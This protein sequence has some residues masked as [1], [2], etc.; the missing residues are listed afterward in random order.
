MSS[1]WPMP[2]PLPEVCCVEAVAPQDGQRLVN[3][4]VGFMDWLMLP[5]AAW[6]QGCRRR[7]GSGG[8]LSFWLGWLMILPHLKL[9]DQDAMFGCDS[10]SL[11]LLEGGQRLLRPNLVLIA[12]SPWLWPSIFLVDKPF[13]WISGKLRDKRFV[14]AKVNKKP[15]ALPCL[16]FPALIRFHSLTRP[17]QLCICALLNIDLVY[18]VNLP[19]SGGLS[20]RPGWRCSNCS[21]CSRAQAAWGLCC[22]RKRLVAS[23]RPCLL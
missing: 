3:V 10:Q 2:L 6:R 19:R 21:S 16:D 12:P 17:L 15:L 18:L 23:P 4:A 13:G 5:C 22:R 1:C 14:T 20:W 8:W 11:A 7:G 9:E